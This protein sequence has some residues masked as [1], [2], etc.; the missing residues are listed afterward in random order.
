[1]ITNPMEKHATAPD[2]CAMTAG[3][4]EM[5]STVCPTMATTIDHIIV[6]NRPR[7]WSA[8]NAPNRGMR[9]DQNELTDCISCGQNVNKSNSHNVNPVDA[10]W[11]IP[12]A[13][14]TEPSYPAPVVEPSGRGRWMKLTTVSLVFWQM[15]DIE[16]TYKQ[17]WCHST[18]TARIARQR[19]L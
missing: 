11:P 2:G 13:P 16:I 4:A 14:G 5:T 3:M 8:T 7:Y 18:R 12:S 10:R 6:R 17:P 9:Y 1:M 19:P 15:A